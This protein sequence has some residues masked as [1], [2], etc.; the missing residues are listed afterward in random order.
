MPASMA[1]CRLGAG[2]PPLGKFEEDGL[3]A[4]VFGPPDFL[5]E[6]VDAVLTLLD[7]GAEMTLIALGVG[8]VVHC[9]SPSA[10]TQEYPSL[11]VP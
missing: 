3:A 10:K 4:E 11:A 9:H 5:V 2:V 7:A 1:G 6:P 8:V